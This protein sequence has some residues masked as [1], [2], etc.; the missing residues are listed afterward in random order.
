MGSGKICSP[1]VIS[2]KL[3]RERE[4][5]RGGE[6]KSGGI[7]RHGE[8]MERREKAGGRLCFCFV[9]KKGEREREGKRGMGAGRHEFTCN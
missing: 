9:L 7:D 2:Y 1:A 3:E 8:K 6:R 5:C 4:K